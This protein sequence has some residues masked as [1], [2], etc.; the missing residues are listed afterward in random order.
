MCFSFVI[1]PHSRVSEQKF[2]VVNAKMDAIKAD[3]HEKLET[4]KAQMLLI[5][6]HLKPNKRG[7]YISVLPSTDY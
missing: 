2:K 7:Y 6:R 4:V 5:F 1:S 3:V